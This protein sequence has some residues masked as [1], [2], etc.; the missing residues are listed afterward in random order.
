M[1]RGDFLIEV[2]EQPASRLLPAYVCVRARLITE[3]GSVQ[4]SFTV[5]PHGDRGLAQRIAMSLCEAAP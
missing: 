2:L 1:K 5:P 4:R 3:D